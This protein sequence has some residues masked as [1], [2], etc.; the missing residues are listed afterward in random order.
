MASVLATTDGAAPNLGK[1]RKTDA[2]PNVNLDAAA[3]DG[4]A[5]VPSVGALPKLNVGRSVT[6]AMPKGPSRTGGA[7]DA[8]PAAADTGPVTEAD[9]G[10]R[11]AAA[12]LTAGCA[13]LIMTE[14]AARAGADAGNR[15]GADRVR[16]VAAGRTAAAPAGAKPDSLA[17]AGRLSA[18]AAAGLVPDSHAPKAAGARAAGGMAPA[19]AALRAGGAAASCS[20][21]TVLLTCTWLTA[22]TTGMMTGTDPVAAGGALPVMKL[23]GSAELACPNLKDVPLDTTAGGAEAWDSTSLAVGAAEA[24][25]GS[26]AAAWLAL[27]RTKPGSTGGPELV[28]PERPKVKLRLA[29]DCCCCASCA[30]TAASA[31]KGARLQGS[32]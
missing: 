25:A 26:D 13:A 14:P 20:A 15:L 2:L 1:P 3:A 4:A 21:G 9:A 30:C 10:G 16:V 12:T 31:Y 18:A 17:V 23:L 22:A 11:G 6:V 8:A 24:L 7:D 19:C 32:A 29:E 27:A 5:A 28:R